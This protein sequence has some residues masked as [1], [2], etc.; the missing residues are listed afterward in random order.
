MTVINPDELAEQ[1]V[2]KA[3]AVRRIKSAIDPVLGG[4]LAGAAGGALLGGGSAAAGPKKKKNVGRSALMGATAGAGVGVGAGALG[5][6][7]SSMPAGTFATPSS[8]LPPGIQD[9]LPEIASQ[10]DK[11]DSPLASPVAAVGD[12]LSSYASNHPILAAIASGDLLSHVGGAVGNMAR[13]HTG[14]GMPS[15][16]TSD[17]FESMRNALTKGKDTHQPKSGPQDLIHNALQELEAN[18]TKA[19]GLL[20]RVRT[21]IQDGAADDVNVGHG[22]QLK[23]V[24][25][26]KPSQ[27]IQPM[28]S[29]DAVDF[30]RW[31]TGSGNSAE[32]TGSKF[33]PSKLDSSVGGAG[34]LS[35]DMHQF[36]GTTDAQFRSVGGKEAPGITPKWFGLSDNLKDYSGNPIN[37]GAQFSD[38]NGNAGKSM[39]RWWKDAL[40]RPTQDFMSVLRDGLMEPTTSSAAGHSVFNR[41]QEMLQDST[42][43]DKSLRN[44][45]SMLGKDTGSIRSKIQDIIQG[46]YIEHASRFATPAKT[47]AL[48]DIGSQVMRSISGLEL[49]GRAKTW[50]GAIGSRAALYGGV[51]M[52]QS[53]LGGYLSRGA[54]QSKLNK[55]IQDAIGKK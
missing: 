45:M 34:K 48:P 13:R 15:M 9:K 17:L 24:K 6:A 2:T 55:L 31:V 47:E 3:A 51:P 19:H 49:P 25:S 20:H 5:K 32:S 44:V 46:K 40:R 22:L 8:S 14:E 29:D 28:T 23:H 1:L 21:A 33:I 4:A 42:V 41:I 11:A 37:I 54:E 53:L 10:L 38:A 30:L 39:S 18:P 7:L 50:A 35:P 36:L 52:L 12:G 27:G 43:E 26:L 16:R